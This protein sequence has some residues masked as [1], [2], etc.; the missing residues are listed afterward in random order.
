MTAEQ[1]CSHKVI[2]THFRLEKRNRV[3]KGIV[4]RNSGLLWEAVS[5]AKDTG[6][7]EIPELL[8]LKGVA[9][10]GPLMPDTFA[11]FFQTKIIG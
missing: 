3:R 8:H 5:I 7:S 10:E 6:M 2:Q 4:P 11:K 1:E 9:V